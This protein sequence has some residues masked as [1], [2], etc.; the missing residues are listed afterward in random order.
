[1]LVV[2]AGL[3][4]R[5]LVGAPRALDGLAVN[6]LRAVQPFGV[7]STSAGQRGRST[8]SPA[9]ACSFA[10]ARMRAIS[11]TISSRVTAIRSW[12]AIGSSPSKPPS[13]T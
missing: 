12:T 7:R 2:V 8:G 13:T 9:P 6:D 11:A 3:R 10:V 4:E 1:V 5:H